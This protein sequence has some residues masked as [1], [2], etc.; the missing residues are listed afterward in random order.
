MTEDELKTAAD[1]LQTEISGGDLSAAYAALSDQ[2]RVA[3]QEVDLDSYLPGGT[4]ELGMAAGRGDAATFFAAFRRRMRDKLCAEGGELTTL[5]KVGAHTT[6]SQI[7][8]ALLTVVPL[9]LEAAGLLYPIAAI[10]ATTGIEA[11]CER[12]H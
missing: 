5:S 8:T 7:V 1:T 3:S 12:S 9:P 11:F 4:A 2:L 10:I 6:A